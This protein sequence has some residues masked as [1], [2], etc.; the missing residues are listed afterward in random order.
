MLE[1]SVLLE[2]SIIVMLTGMLTVFVFLG[3][4]IFATKLMSALILK[5]VPQPPAPE[6]PTA[7]GEDEAAIAAAIAAAQLRSL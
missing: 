5:F 6:A 2:D 7:A 3:I 4:L 1:Q